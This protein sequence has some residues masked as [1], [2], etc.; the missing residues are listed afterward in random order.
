MNEVGHGMIQGGLGYVWAAYTVTWV[1]LA[2]YV[3]RVF[4]RG[5]ARR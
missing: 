4:A 5:E 2:F 3:A 1:V